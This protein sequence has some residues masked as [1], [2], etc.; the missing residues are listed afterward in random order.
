MQLG[1]QKSFVHELWFAPGIK[2]KYTKLLQEADGAF[3]EPR[4]PGVYVVKSGSASPVKE[5]R[6][7]R[8]PAPKNNPGTLE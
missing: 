2:P 4:L 5:A 7:L 6:G 8:D 3:I 1:L